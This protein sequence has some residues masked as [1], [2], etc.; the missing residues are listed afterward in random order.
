MFKDGGFFFLSLAMT[1]EEDGPSSRRRFF[2]FA[3]GDSFFTSYQL[4]DVHVLVKMF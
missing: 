4:V 1:G 2:L 3:E